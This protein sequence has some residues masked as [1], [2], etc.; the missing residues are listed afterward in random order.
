M[1]DSMLE[2]PQI[3]VGSMSEA[4]VWTFTRDAYNSVMHHVNEFLLSHHQRLAKLRNAMS[5]ELHSVKD[6]ESQQQDTAWPRSDPGDY[7]RS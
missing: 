2:F 6:Q 7:S 1:L 5:E 4:D 3:D